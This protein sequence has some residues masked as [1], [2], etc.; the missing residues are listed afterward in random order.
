MVLLI[1]IV[2]VTNILPLLFGMSIKNVRNNQ[3]N[4]LETYD[5]L[6]NIQSTNHLNKH[7][8]NCFETGP[9]GRG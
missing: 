9:I 2:E 3:P 7:S 4:R 1:Y 8:V 5:D 6:P